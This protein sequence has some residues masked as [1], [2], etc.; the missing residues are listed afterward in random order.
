MS[1]RRALGAV[2]LCNQRQHVTWQNPLCFPERLLVDARGTGL[3]RASSKPTYIIVEGRIGWR[4]LP[5]RQ[6]ASHHSRRACARQ[7]ETRRH[8]AKPSMFSRASTGR[9][10]GTGA[11]WRAS[12]RCQRQPTP[13]PNLH[14]SR[15]AHWSAHAMRRPTPPATAHRPFHGHLT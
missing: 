9:R 2:A 8:M 3:R 7:A 15:R 11:S 13:R 12:P 5:A 14:H 4:T 1:P 6:P 10:S